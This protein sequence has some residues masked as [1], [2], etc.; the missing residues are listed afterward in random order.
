LTP[1][2]TTPFEL[3]VAEW[4]L[5]RLDTDDL[6]LAGEFF[7]RRG[8]LV[9]APALAR[10][11]L[12]RLIAKLEITDETYRQYDPAYVIATILRAKARQS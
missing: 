4:P 1:L 9:N 2:G 3:S 12:A 7:Q 11:I 6:L 10:A 5:E 8:A